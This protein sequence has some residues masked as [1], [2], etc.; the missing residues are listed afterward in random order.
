VKLV[1]FDLDGTLTQ[2]MGV[3]VECFVIAVTEVLQLPEIDQDWNSY[4]HV[5]DEGVIREL[6]MRSFGRQA[7]PRDTIPVVDRFIE[8][9]AARQ[10]SDGTAFSEISGATPL[11]DRL[12]GDSQWAIALAT[13]AW[14]RSAQFKIRSAGLPLEG[15]PAAFAE[16]GPSR[17]GIVRA[18]IDRAKETYR[19]LEF[20]RIVSVGDALWDV[21]TARNLQFPFV[22]VGASSRAERLRSNGASHVLED[23]RDPECF[24]RYLEEARIP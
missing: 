12:R 18:A 11:M 19:Q 20:E 15:I 22:G 3:D 7:Q 2:T 8:L 23:Y 14:R 17:E 1:V 9:L 5:T 10:L 16:D 24:L 13:G 21:K 6:F 4:E